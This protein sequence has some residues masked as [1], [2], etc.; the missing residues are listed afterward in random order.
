MLDRDSRSGSGCVLPPSSA[1][2]L[3]WRGVQ[4]EVDVNADEEHGSG[5]SG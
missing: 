2:P 3:T 1:M 4:H 5:S